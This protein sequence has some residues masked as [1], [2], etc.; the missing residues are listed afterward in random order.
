M[1][2]LARQDRTSTSERRGR[3][4]LPTVPESADNSA[5]E[6]EPNGD[7]RPAKLTW[8]VDL[9]SELKALTTFDLWMGLSSGELAR[10]VKVWRVGREAWE[11]ACDVPE[12]A[13]ALRDDVL[14]TA[15]DAIESA[16]TRS[17]LE[18]SSRPPFG[19]DEE[20]AA[21]SP[22]PPSPAE[23]TPESPLGAALLEAI[24]PERAISEA[25]DER[26]DSV[27][28]APRS[29]TRLVRR[30]H[31]SRR[32]FAAGTLA[33]GAAA[34]LLLGLSS[35][36]RAPVTSLPEISGEAAAGLE[37][38]AQNLGKTGGESP[39]AQALGR[40]ADE[41]SPAPT[42]KRRTWSPSNRGQTRR[43]QGSF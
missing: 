32:V 7:P 5:L 41:A 2:E 9:G 13:C 34:L 12:L 17:T 23:L 21:E 22:L 11:P 31:R 8:A 24:E 3:V 26:P 1:T 25:P 15:D 42:A 18:Y 33:A 10:T 37:P 19:Q 28:A 30:S 27:P 40:Q 6:L 43:R 39:G 38:I 36:W 29:N 16:T 20:V 35:L 14:P 4:S